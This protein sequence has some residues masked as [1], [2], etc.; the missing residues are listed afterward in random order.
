MQATATGTTIRRL[1]AAD[2]GAL[3]A[4]SSRLGADSEKH[5][6]E[7]FAH[8]DL[9]AVGAESNGT[10]VAYAAGEVRRSFGRSAAAGWIDAFGVDLSQRGRGVGRELAAA[11]L[12]EL[13]AAG[14]DHVFTL[15]PV[16]DR[17]LAPFFRDL[18]FRDEEFLCVGRDL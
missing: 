13:R 12:A 9:V 18:G 3:S 15:V 16:H 2:I 17:T 1:A 11:F 5:W 14:A 4:L 10:L 6:A 7:R 8:A